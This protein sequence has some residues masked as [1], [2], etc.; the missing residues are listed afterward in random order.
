MVMFNKNAPKKKRKPTTGFSELN[1]RTYEA[2]ESCRMERAKSGSSNISA[3]G[4][5]SNNQIGSQIGNSAPINAVHPSSNQQAIFNSAPLPQSNIGVSPFQPVNNNATAFNQTPQQMSQA[6]N[7]APPQNKQAFN[8]AYIQNSQGFSPVNNMPASNFQSGNSGGFSPMQ[9]NNINRGSMQRPANQ[10][11][12]Q[13]NNFQGQPGN[14]N[15]FQRNNAPAPANNQQRFQQNNGSNLDDYSRNGADSKY[16]KA[17][18]NNQKKKKI[19]RIVVIA[20]SALAA[21]LLIVGI[22]F[23]VISCNMNSGMDDIG[24]TP[25]SLNEPFYMVLMGVDSSE[26]RKSDGG[27]DED[28]RSDSIILA[29]I[30]APDKKVSLLSLHRDIEVDMGKYGTQKLNAAHSLG[31]PELVIKTI[32]D[33]CGVK[34]NHYAEINFDGFKAAVDDL[35]GVYMNVPMEIADELAGYVPE[36]EQI[37]NGDQA[38]AMCRSRHSFDD[39]GDGDKY[40][41]A[42]QRAVLTAIAHQA[43]NSDI[44]AIA[45][46]VTDLSKYIKTDLKLNDMVGLAQLM[47]D[48]DPNKD[49]YSAMTPTEGVYKNGAWYEELDKKELEKMMKR[50]D[51]GDPPS[52]ETVIDPM[53]GTVM[54]NAGRSDE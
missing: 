29:R 13:Y 38:L 23:A 12:P 51:A 19:R 11:A 27:T 17:H 30:S 40:R 28:Y 53:T 34:I 25:T 43:L 31:G 37:L 2:S 39:F 32:S 10:S 20:A 26:E 15:S 44:V 1:R 14:L 36:G 50:M 9:N 54:S 47:K 48:V 42:N 22:A 8:Q 45:K 21:L 7:S 49:I 33:L 3:S 35:G 24:L 18:Q 16:R 52:D 5:I 41:A 6:F 4:P 46:T